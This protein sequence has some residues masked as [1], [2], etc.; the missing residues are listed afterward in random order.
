MGKI[1]YENNMK[2]KKNVPEEVEYLREYN[3]LNELIKND[4][5]MPD[6]LVDLLIRFLVQHHG[7]LSNRAREKEFKELTSSEA[8]AVEQKYKTVFN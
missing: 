7:T 3:L 1:Y 8:Q 4:I 2:S 6:K 5:D